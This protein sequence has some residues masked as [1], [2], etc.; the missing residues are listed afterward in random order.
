MFF[1]GGGGCSALTGDVF[2]VN[3]FVALE[4]ASSRFIAYGAQGILGKFCV[5]FALKPDFQ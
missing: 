3:I 1:F 4:F 5:L 2:A